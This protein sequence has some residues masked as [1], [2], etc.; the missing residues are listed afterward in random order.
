MRILQLHTSY[1]EAGGEDAVVRAEA[2][3]LRRLGHE[4]VE[5]RAHNPAGVVGASV[6]LSLSPWNPHA[7]RAVLRAV[8]AAQPDV[9]HVHNTWYAMSPAVLGPLRRAGVPVV[10]TL[11]NFRL[12]C[13]NALL[14]RDGGPCELCV[15][16]H[17]WNAVRHRC[18]RG[19]AVL[20]VPAAGAI[21]LHQ[22]L[23]TW[24]QN[25]DLFVALNE[26][27]RARFIRGGLPPGRTL[28]KPNFVA[29][30]GPRGRPPS[31]S[32]TVLY[33]GRLGPEKG[34]D[35]LLDAWRRLGE[36]PLKLV[37]VGD[38]PLQAQ[39]ERQAGPSVRFEGRRSPED[40]RRHMLTARALVFPSICYENQPMAV[41]E[42][43]AAGLPVL[44]SATGG[45]PE[46]LQPVG[47][48]W[49]VA[50]RDV[51]AWVDALRL[52]EDDG[53]VDEGSARARASYERSF[54]E[55]SAGEA[56]VAVYERAQAM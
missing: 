39:L 37:I 17:P 15:G 30:P 33:V 40:V 18:Y 13:A 22:A 51:S 46:L 26:F 31:S 55:A 8:E 48:Q 21:A 52:L 25:V 32:P 47:G 38:G 50:P 7:A 24:E 19:S 16:S 2:D 54:T 20:S 3:L 27:A 9:A 35:V 12:M 43:L 45:V 6:A 10:A 23:G 44:G 34:V 4:V 53:W 41:L 29:D 42:A 14:F 56:L 11:H 1:R 5:H 49:L 36:T 28:V